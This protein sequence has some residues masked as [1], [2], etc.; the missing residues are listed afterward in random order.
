MIAA[1]LQGGR[2]FHLGLD[3]DLCACAPVSVL[4]ETSILAYGP[5][6]TISTQLNTGWPLN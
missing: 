4:R 2:I 1:E 3:L 5:E 6:I